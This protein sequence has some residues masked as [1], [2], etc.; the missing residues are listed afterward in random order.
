MGERQVLKCMGE[1]N[2]EV[3]YEWIHKQVDNEA[4]GESVF[5]VDQTG[6]N[7]YL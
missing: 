3:H 6:K 2:P 4:E 5:S 7:L 1:G